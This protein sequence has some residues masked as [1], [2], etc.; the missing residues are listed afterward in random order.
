[1]G[2]MKNGI[3]TLDVHEGSPSILG[4]P[5]FT[6]SSAALMD[7]IAALVACGGPHLI[8]TPNVD[9]MLELNDNSEFRS[10]YSL[11]S[12]LVIDG[13]PIAHLAR[14]LGCRDAPRY[15]G[16]DLLPQASS[17]SCSRHWTIAIAGGA[18]GV[19]VAAAERLSGQ[20]PG[21]EVV[22]VPFPLLSSVDDPASLGVIEDLVRVRPHL[23]FLCLG[24]PK[25]ELWYSVWRSA[26][27]SAVYIA[28]GAA[29]DFAAGVVS[30]APRWIQR[31][32]LEWAWRLSQ[33][34]SRLWHRYLVRGP[35]FITTAWA[36]VLANR[37]TAT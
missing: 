37:S 6:G 25:Q 22:A 21:A 5:V 33:E 28:S 27:P 35:R 20:F 13:M 19:A 32:S 11:A 17:E 7:R 29:A 12:L 30:R 2:P 36:S 9:Q 23:V 3:V 34:P 1:M 14:R 15:T 18:T 16:A 8:A 10:A 26:L 24:C 4:V 31:A